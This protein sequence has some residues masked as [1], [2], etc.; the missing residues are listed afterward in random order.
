LPRTPSR[1]AVVEETVHA[2]FLARGYSDHQ[3]AESVVSEKILKDVLVGDHDWQVHFAD[4][5]PSNEVTFFQKTLGDYLIV[6]FESNINLASVTPETV[7]SAWE[8]LKR[9][10]GDIA[11]CGWWAY[12]VASP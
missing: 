3:D 12:K 7:E 9:K 6:A 2:V 10:F 5:E 8:G 1:R 4:I 11:G